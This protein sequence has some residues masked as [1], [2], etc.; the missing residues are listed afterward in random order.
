MN[1]KEKFQQLQE[2]ILKLK[3][4]QY[5]I[6]VEHYDFTNDKDQWT[7]LFNSLFNEIPILE[8]QLKEGL[9]ND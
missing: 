1:D 5:D 2:Q 4:E 7:K 6:A 8:K 3:K 9:F